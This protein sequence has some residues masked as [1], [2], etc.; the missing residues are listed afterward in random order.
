MTR[1]L[2][3]LGTSCDATHTHTHT[4]TH[5]P[6]RSLSL[7]ELPGLEDPEPPPPPPASGSSSGSGPEPV[8]SEHTMNTP[9]EL[10]RCSSSSNVVRRLARKRGTSRY[11]YEMMLVDLR[12]FRAAL[13]CDHRWSSIAGRLRYGRNG[14][15][16]RGCTGH[17]LRH[18]F[19]TGR[20]GA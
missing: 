2:T 1:R 6:P 17:L 4:H 20:R 9:S 7:L 13:Q 8:R 11:T 12:T 18:C 14:S 19:F 3:Y 5:T 15:N 10:P 16:E